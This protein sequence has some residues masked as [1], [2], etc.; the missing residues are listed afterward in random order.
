MHKKERIPD[1]IVP[2][3]GSAMDYLNVFKRQWQFMRDQ[4]TDQE[5]S[6][7]IA[8][9]SAQ[10][11]IWRLVHAQAVSTAQYNGWLAASQ[12][13]LPIC[14][15]LS[16]LGQ[17]VITVQCRPVKVKFHTNITKCGPQPGTKTIQLI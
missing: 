11:D 2:T 4:I 6:L 10:C 3:E 9:H 8:V 5:N 16:A 12:L 14:T 13:R 7:S 17:T 1:I 15:K